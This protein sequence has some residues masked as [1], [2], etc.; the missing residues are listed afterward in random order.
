MKRCPKCSR[1]YPTDTQRFC[2]HDGGMLVPVEITPT[3]AKEFD[4]ASA[5]TKV[6]SR[7]LVSEDT[8]QFDP[9]RTTIGTS[10]AASERTSEVRG[11]DT[12]SLSPEAPPPPSRET[13]APLPPP[14]SGPISSPGGGTVAPSESWEPQPTLISLPPPPAGPISQPGPEVAAPWTATQPPVTSGSLP[15]SGSGPIVTSAPLPAPS[16]GSLPSPTF[17]G[18]SQPQQVQPLAAAVP[19]K[20]KSKAPLIIG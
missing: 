15:Q 16:S 1:N 8:V 13:S 7:E 18:V 6:I 17:T 5:P 2:T 3:E 10:A 11:R 12:G 20:K 19:P 4:A 14:P 9:F